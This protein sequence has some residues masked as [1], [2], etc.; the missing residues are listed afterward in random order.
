MPETL[1]L[2]SAQLGSIDDAGVI[3]L[4]NTTKSPRP[5]NE[6]IVPG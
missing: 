2:T 5:T 1:C 6:P 3:I 4:S